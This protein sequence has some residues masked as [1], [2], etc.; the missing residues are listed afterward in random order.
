MAAFF[1]SEQLLTVAKRA[2]ALGIDGEMLLELDADGWKEFGITSS[3]QRTQLIVLVRRAAAASTVINHPTVPTVETTND[4][5]RP[6]EHTAAT[7]PPPDPHC[8][9]DAARVAVKNT[10]RVARKHA[11][12]VSPMGGAEHSASWN[13]AVGEANVDGANVK[14]H[15]LGFLAM[16][17]V[18]ALLVFTIGFTCLFSSPPIIAPTEG[19]ATKMGAEIAGRNP[20]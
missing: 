18:L 1:K 8:H 13:V 11:K 7:T 17:N 20:P 12:N 2:L 14:S 4:A 5:D 9:P 6:I 3:I 15:V 16:Y 19:N 10:A